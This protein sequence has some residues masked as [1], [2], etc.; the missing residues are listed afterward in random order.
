MISLAKLGFYRFH[1]SDVYFSGGSEQRFFQPL[2]LVVL[3]TRFKTNE[4]GH[5]MPAKTD[6]PKLKQRALD[7]GEYFQLVTSVIPYESWSSP[8]HK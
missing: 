5:K 8:F 3:S 4:P 2:A 1:A 7:A 6:L